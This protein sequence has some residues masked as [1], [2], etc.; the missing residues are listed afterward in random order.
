M[1]DYY[2]QL[3][4]L[5]SLLYI[6]IHLWILLMVMN[7]TVES[8]FRQTSWYDVQLILPK[9][10]YVRL[11]TLSSLYQIAPE[12]ISIVFSTTLHSLHI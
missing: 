10:Q 3:C 12:R 5:F 1:E 8:A 4:I 7:Q 6:F 9:S 11:N 2:M